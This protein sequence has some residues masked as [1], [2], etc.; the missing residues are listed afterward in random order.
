VA[1]A[2]TGTTTMMATPGRHGVRQVHA[3]ATAGR[4]GLA[5]LLV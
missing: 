1:V 5:A 4:V 2:P 3:F